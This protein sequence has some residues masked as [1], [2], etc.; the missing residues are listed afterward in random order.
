MSACFDDNKTLFVM[1]IS[2]VTL[3]AKIDIHSAS[4]ECTTERNVIC[5]ARDQYSEYSC[6]PQL[7][8]SQLVYVYHSGS[9]HVT[10]PG[11]VRRLLR[12]FR[13]TCH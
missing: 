5:I 1:G 2:P 8:S 11:N 10:M 7:V 9:F 3:L 13:V 12:Y 4:F 6:E